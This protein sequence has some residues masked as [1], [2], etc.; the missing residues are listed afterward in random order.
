MIARRTAVAAVGLYA[1]LLV[2]VA[3]ARSSTRHVIER[4]GVTHV[5]VVGEGQIR[6]DGLGPE[7]WAFR[8]H[9]EQRIVRRLQVALA[10]RLARQVWLISAFE[11][12]HSHEGSWTANTGNG[13]TGGLQFG[14]P[15]WTT[16]GRSFAARADLASPSEQIAAGIT[17]WS[18]AGF[19]P[20]PNTARMCGL[21]P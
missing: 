12:I 1:L 16:Y 10:A 11:C 19:A 21:L 13:Y 7:R 20:W 8:F 6:F 18:V 17:Y 15:E 3:A 9:R 2:L 5:R 4:S 14:F